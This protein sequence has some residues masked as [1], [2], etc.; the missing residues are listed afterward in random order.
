MGAVLAKGQALV[1]I[2]DPE[3]RMRGTGFV[4]DGAGTV[5]TG[6]AAVHG[7]RRVVVHAPGGRSHTADASGIT[8]LPE[9]DLAL[10]R[11]AGLDVAPL[12]IGA[13]PPASRRT[14]VLLC[15]ADG[16]GARTVAAE[17]SGSPVTVV[18][19]AAGRCHDVEGVLELTLPDGALAAD[20]SGVRIPG[21]PVLN[22]RTGAVLAVLGTALHAPGAVPRT[23]YAV[24]LRTAGRW[25][26]EGPLGLLVARN[27]ATVPGFGADLNL[28][29]ALRLTAATVRSGVRRGAQ[30]A[31]GRLAERPEVARALREFE[32]SGAS[33]TAL[34]GRPGTGRTT[35]LAVLAE[36]RANA[37]APA[38]TVWLR[39]AELR[40]GDGGLREALGRALADG[41][42]RLGPTEPEWVP[43]TKTVHA[44]R[45]GT[46]RAVCGAAQ[47][48]VVAGL[49]RTA[50]R[51]LLVLLD[52]PEEMPPSLARDLRRW[53]TGTASWLRTS[54]A[55]LVIACGPELW[56]ELG[57][58]LPA[59]LLYGGVERGEAADGA[60]DGAPP[61]VHLGELC[62]PQAARARE[63]YGVGAGEMAPADAGHPLALRMLAEIH[64]AQGPAAG[65]AHRDDHGRPTAV[66]GDG[67]P[68]RD[69]IFDAYLDLAAL[70]IANR[71]ARTAVG[72]A[73]PARALRR[74]AA[75]T[76]G[77]LHEAAR[78]CLGPGQG[79]LRRDDFDA[80]FPRRGG[81]ADAVLAEGVMEAAGEEFRFADEE[82]GDW[83]QGRH[84]DVDAA[85]DALVHGA[86][87]DARD[88]APR[89]PVSAAVLP[90]HRVG[91]VVHALVLGARLDGT[92]ALERRLR[93]LAEVALAGGESGAV[94]WAR[95]LLRETLLRLPD[96]RPCDGLLR[97]LAE[98]IADGD[99]D[100]GYADEGY[101]DEGYGSER[102]R[103]SADGPSYPDGFGPS[104]WRGLALP[105][106][107]RAGLLRLLLPADPPPSGPGGRRE[108]ERFL[109]VVGDMLEAE[110]ATV[111]PLL[112]GWFT[113]RR[114]LADRHRDGRESGDVCQLPRPTVA[115]AA[116]ALLY[117]HRRL[118]LDTTLDLLTDACHPRADELLGD[119]AQEEPAA[120]C[121]AVERWARQEGALRQIAAAE[122]GPRMVARARTDDDRL[123][124]ER[125]A[126]A[127]L[128]IP[129]D[130]SPYATAALAMLLR[131]GHG[132]RPGRINRPQRAQG[133]DSP[134]HLGTA[135]ALLAATGSAE[136]SRALTDETAD[137]PATALDA[138]RTHLCGRPGGGAHHLTAALAAVRR[139]D[140][141]E[142]TAD[143]VREYAE[144]RPETAAE[145]IAAFVRHRLAH[146][147]EGCAGLRLLTRALAGTPYG[148]LRT[149]L[150]RALG[151]PGGPVPEEPP[152]V[153]LDGERDPAALEAALQAVAHDRGAGHGPG[154]VSADTRGRDGREAPG[155]ARVPC[156]TR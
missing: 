79:A 58:L 24:P 95:T 16:A 14:P 84:L 29:G 94:W 119:L 69:D 82:F 129:G 132:R 8:P 143:V 52:A 140:L 120:L 138:F 2:C 9:W 85:L 10:I 149:G 51:G 41:A 135:L 20:G 113:D 77:A 15:T 44:A 53:A 65:G 104:F 60:R 131:L 21:A 74:L 46:E 12:L 110:P 4:A 154:S 128:R 114:P 148:P 83:L 71:L 54:G 142:A 127:L 17:L 91:V 43:K 81:W 97:G 126:Q 136:L 72:P 98:R 34:V 106:A 50:R 62:G 23:A 11:T 102:E 99:A 124:L 57:E 40:A 87:A 19:S 108:E 123:R 134:G 18:R 75:R 68:G 103:A 111:L 13:E 86:G 38:P 107:Q 32:G 146:R 88:G 48:D 3:G 93:P 118:A 55:R 33:V 147:P 64:A 78:R 156:V 7:L 117:T 130:P 42:P 73:C 1:R 27:G 76:A 35:Q 39:G 56:A 47:A 115:S 109:D 152:A 139:P 141:A 90:R 89:R 70:R 80:V 36:R 26:P 144:M 30:G 121:R 66:T 150:A 125:G 145:A 133:P 153:F 105:T 100:E 92:A 116:Q 37:P 101:A 31:Y 5:V 67:P 112:C 22:A 151:T 61:C 28:A 63:L 45:T 137:R 122:Y 155:Q 59:E 49:A 96:A 25:E 6:H